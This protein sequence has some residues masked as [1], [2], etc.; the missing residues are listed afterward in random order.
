[1]VQ[2]QGPPA[3]PGALQASERDNGVSTNGVT[4][5]YCFSTEGIYLYL[6]KSA[7]AYLLPQS[8]KIVTFAAAPLVLTPLVR[9]QKYYYY[10]YYHYHCYYY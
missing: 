9:N 2:G 4:A 5:I 8:V 7:K 6:P 1:M 10:Y 3:P